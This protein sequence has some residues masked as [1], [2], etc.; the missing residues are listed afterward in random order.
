[1][2]ILETKLTEICST[3]LIDLI[4]TRFGFQKENLP[5]LCL[6]V[7]LTASRLTFMQFQPFILRISN[8]IGVFTAMDVENALEMA[9]SGRFDM[10]FS[11]VDVG[12]KIL[13]TIRHILIVLFANYDSREMVVAI[14]REAPT[15][16]SPS[17]LDNMK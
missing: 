12:L 14:R 2:A 1:M 5:I 3:Q 17:R 16:S 7:S 13:K 15:S 8:Y 11:E 10:I 4:V 6:G 9:Q